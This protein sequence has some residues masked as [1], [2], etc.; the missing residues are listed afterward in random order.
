[1]DKSKVLMDKPAIAAALTRIAHEIVEQN[2]ELGNLALVGII[3]RG[4]ILAMEISKKVAEIAEVQLPV[5]SLDI[6][7]YRDDVSSKIPDVYKTDISFSIDGRDVILVDDILYTGRTI[8]GA[9]DALM[10]YGRPARIQLAVLADRGHR[11]LPIRADYVG[12]NIPTAKN[13]NVRLYLSAFDGKDSVEVIG[14]KTDERAGA[15]PLTLD[16]DEYDRV[17]GDINE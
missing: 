11:E 16:S 12:K 15:V 10:D 13:E 8:R 14:L 7:F 4:D 2:E 3:T 1:M 9:L 6:S 17:K 5:G